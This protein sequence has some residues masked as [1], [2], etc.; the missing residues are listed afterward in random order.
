MRVIQTG[1]LTDAQL[2]VEIGTGD[3]LITCTT[4]QQIDQG[5]ALFCWVDWKKC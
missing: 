2:H 3:G 4:H 1:H 5:H